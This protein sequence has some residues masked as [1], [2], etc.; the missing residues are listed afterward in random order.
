MSWFSDYFSG[1][2]GRMW[3]AQIEVNR[4]AIEVNKELYAE[5]D[6]LKARVAYL[7]GRISDVR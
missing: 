6:K 5:I 7:E 1:S 4:A 3:A 2:P